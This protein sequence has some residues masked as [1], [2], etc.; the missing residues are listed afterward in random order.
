M[1]VTSVGSAAAA[2]QAQ[3][4]PF[5]RGQRRGVGRAVPER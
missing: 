5:D 4:K 3:V 2:V 1:N